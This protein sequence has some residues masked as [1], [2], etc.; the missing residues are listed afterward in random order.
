MFCYLVCCRL[1]FFKFIFVIIPL[2]NLLTLFPPIALPIYA[3]VLYVHLCFI[4][5]RSNNSSLSLV[6]PLFVP[7]WAILSLLRM[8][9]VDL[10]MFKTVLFYLTACLR[11]CLKKYGSMHRSLLIEEKILTWS[12]QLKQGLYLM[13]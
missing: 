8:Y 7:L 1:V 6:Q 10:H 4:H 13:A 2:K 5:K 9:A 11:I 3:Y 12:W